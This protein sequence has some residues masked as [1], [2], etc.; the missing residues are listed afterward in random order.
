MRVIR[1]HGHVV[2]GLVRRADLQRAVTTHLPVLA[3]ARARGDIALPIGL[4]SVEEVAVVWAAAEGAGKEGGEREER[5]PQLAGWP[6]TAASSPHA[7]ER[8]A[9][10]VLGLLKKNFKLLSCGVR[11]THKDERPF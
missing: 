11:V 1:R 4:R 5:Q 3:L 9:I 6:S 10:T 7:P 8:A 2:P